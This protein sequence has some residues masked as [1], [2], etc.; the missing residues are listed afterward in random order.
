MRASLY[1]HCLWRLFLYPP[2]PL[3]FWNLFSY[4]V[5]KSLLKRRKLSFYPLSLVVYLTKRCNYKCSFCYAQDSLNP[6]NFENDLSLE[7]MKE[8]L[9]NPFG[10]RALRVGLL[11]GEPFL[12]RDIFA[13]I[14]L[15]KKHGKI[16]TVVSNAS[17]ITQEKI[18]LLLDSGLDVLGLSLYDNNHHHV[19]RVAQA[20]RG[21]MKYWIQAVV[22]AREIEKLE[23]MIEF[24]LKIGCENLQISNCVPI[25]GM[26]AD[27]A[28]YD[29][30]TAYFEEEQRLKAK[31][32]GKINIS[33]IQPLPR[34][35]V[36]RACAMP[37][38]YVHVDNKGNLGAC[39]M[40]A[41]DGSKYGNIYEGLK[42]WNSPFYLDLRESMYDITKEPL[43]V[44]RHC[45]NLHQDLYR[46]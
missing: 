2:S 11:G 31:Y 36:K 21:K 29:D 39:C 28:I 24:C 30:H 25:G 8:I 33:W 23:P 40:R 15:L 46:I 26:G 20:I 13:L 4:F 12:N 17:L 34:K 19:E 16:T 18:P 37:F 5:N 3:V 45:D 1:W 9:N 38:S 6:R 10:R 44:C 35:P 7:Q 14:K 32:K 41:P 22:N 43:D 27:C 42:T